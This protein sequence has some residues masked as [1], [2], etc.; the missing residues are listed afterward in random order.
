MGLGTGKLCPL[1]RLPNRDADAARRSLARSGL[2]EGP[3]G[4]E[5]RQHKEHQ[6]NG[7]LIKLNVAEQQLKY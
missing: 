7:T 5:R 2:E 3:S 4:A 6:P 1:V